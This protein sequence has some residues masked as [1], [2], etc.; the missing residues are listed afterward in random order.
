MDGFVEARF[1]WWDF[2]SCV[3]FYLLQADEYF[4]YFLSEHLINFFRSVR[5]YM[6]IDIRVF[7]LCIKRRGSNGVFERGWSDSVFKVGL[8]VVDIYA[9]VCWFL[10]WTCQCYCRFWV[11]CHDFSNLGT[12]CFNLQ[13]LAELFHSFSTTFGRLCT[14]F[15][16]RWEWSLLVSSWGFAEY[17]AQVPNFII[18]ELWLILPC[19]RISLRTLSFT[20]IDIEVSGICLAV[21]S[22]SVPPE[23]CSFRLKTIIEISLQCWLTTDQFHLVSRFYIITKCFAAVIWAENRASRSFNC[24]WDRFWLCFVDRD[25]WRCSYGG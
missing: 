7:C 2:I 6:G 12:I 15:S 4:W 23:Y 11:F 9:C 18:G 8:R 14:A 16:S 3:L 21:V 1:R 22:F 5:A 10:R 13:I 20:N 19:W 17:R 25:C 24:Q